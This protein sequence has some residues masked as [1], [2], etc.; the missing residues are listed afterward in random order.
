MGTNDFISAPEEPSNIPSETDAPEEIQKNNPAYLET[1]FKLVSANPT[2]SNDM[3]DR[4]FSLN[5]GKVIFGLCFAE[6]S[7][8]FLVALP[9]ILHNEQGAIDGKF[10]TT[11]PIIRLMKNGISFMGMPEYEHKYYFYRF[12]IEHLDMIPD[13]FNPDR[14]KFMIDVM[15]GWERSKKNGKT[16]E[17][18]ARE[19]FQERDFEDEPELYE[20]MRNSSYTSKTRH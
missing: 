18:E 4:F 12:L 19:M 10:I 6:L 20:A 16:A 9:T 14:I 2:K 13:F 8:S 1:M 5:T 15:E 11:N 3:A 7:D 17:D